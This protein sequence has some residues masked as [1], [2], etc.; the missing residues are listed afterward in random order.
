MDIEAFRGHFYLE[1]PDLH[2]PPNQSFG[3][4]PKL[5]MPLLGSLLNHSEVKP[6]FHIIARSLVR[7]SGKF[8]TEVQIELDN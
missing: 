7:A 5:L 1:N 2:P 4:G 8:L 3:F 6:G